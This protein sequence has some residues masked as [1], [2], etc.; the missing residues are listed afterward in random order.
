MGELAPA[1]RAARSA[2]LLAV[3]TAR[4]PLR[5]VWALAYE[6]AARAFAAWLARG[7]GDV[8]AYAR[9]SLATREP[10]AGLSDLDLVLVA[11]DDEGRRAVERRHERL[12]DRAPWL[13]EALLEAPRVHADGELA[14]VTGET[15]L[16]APFPAYGLSPGAI[17]QLERPGLGDTVAEWRRLR[18]PER[19]A[20]APAAAVRSGGSGAPAAAWL[21]VQYRWQ[22]GWRML[23]GELPSLRS[24]DVAAKLVL[25]PARAWLWLR[26]GALPADR[27]ALLAAAADAEEDVALALATEEAPW[28]G[29]DLARLVPAALRM[30]E[31]VATEVASP[32]AAAFEVAL[33]RA[34]GDGAEGPGS[35]PLADW[36]A[37]VRPEALDSR[38]VPLSDDPR[39]PSV[40]AD[41]QRRSERGSYPCLRAGSLLLL[42]PGRWWRGTLRTIQCPATDPAS[43]AL[44]DGQET[45]R[46]PELPGFSIGDRA[47]RAVAEHDP[48]SP[49]GVRARELLGSVEAGAPVLPC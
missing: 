31:R 44:L 26:D 18:G 25:E 14:R 37:T 17:R 19:R 39:D 48:A 30:A 2:Q 45:A 24:A 20:P 43:F 5:L 29:A 47:R 7:R 16:T 27:P 23:G 38:L 34:E 22:W 32:A 11:A 10:V 13:A 35:L 41:A 6:A 4:G 33:G 12:A 1:P 8:T 46:F 42:A 21:E 28:R 9:G 3:R 15:I 49:G 36:R 40:L